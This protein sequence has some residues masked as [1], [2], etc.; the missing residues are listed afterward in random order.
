M[1][2]INI[3]TAIVVT[4]F[5]LGITLSVITWNIIFF[6]IGSIGIVGSLAL[7]T[8]AIVIKTIKH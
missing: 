1:N 7:G 2:T 5:M 3:I 6:T 8:I 4:M